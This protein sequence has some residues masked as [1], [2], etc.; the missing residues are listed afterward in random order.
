MTKWCPIIVGRTAYL[1]KLSL[2]YRYTYQR[3]PVVTQISLI[4]CH[5]RHD[6]QLKMHHKVFGVLS[7]SGLADRTF[8]MDLRDVAPDKEGEREGTSGK[9]ADCS[10]L[11]A[12]F[13]NLFYEMV[14]NVFLSN[15]V[16]T[17]GLKIL[18]IH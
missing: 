16:D 11:Q 8:L 3:I 6:F 9:S 17:I 2:L 13:N 4:F 14:T 12:Y 15:F 18:K 7:L 1:T 5:Q 10:T